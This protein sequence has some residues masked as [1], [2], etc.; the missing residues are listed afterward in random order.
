[1]RFYKNRQAEMLHWVSTVLKEEHD[2]LAK[3]KYLR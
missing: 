3:L 2:A 1:M